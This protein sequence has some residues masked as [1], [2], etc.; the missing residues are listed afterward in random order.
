MSGLPRVLGQL[1]PEYQQCTDPARL[2]AEIDK[3]LLHI[4]WYRQQLEWLEA[5][6][7]DDKNMRCSFC[8]QLSNEVGKLISSPVDSRKAYICDECIAV[9]NS[10]LAA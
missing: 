8:Q 4:A 3:L 6:V 10:I 2:I 9:C 1:D 5:V 7:A